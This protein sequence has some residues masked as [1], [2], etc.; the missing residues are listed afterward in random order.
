MA[1]NSIGYGGT[2]LGQSVQNINQQL[3]TLSSQ[4]S[5]GKKAATYAGMGR[6][7]PADYYDGE[8]N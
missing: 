5:T 3:A 6:L 7:T 8:D 4:L 1:I 2:V